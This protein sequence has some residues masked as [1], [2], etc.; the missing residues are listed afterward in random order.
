MEVLLALL[1]IFV[2]LIV[3]IWILVLLT[4][5]GRSVG[6]IAE[7]VAMLDMAVAGLRNRS[8]HPA[9][10]TPLQEDAQRTP[11]DERIAAAAARKQATS[12]D[13]SGARNTSPCPCG[14]SPFPEGGKTKGNG[15]T[16]PPSSK[17][18]TTPIMPP[19]ERG[20][21]AVPPRGVF[22][23]APDAGNEA[24]ARKDESVTTPP[25]PGSA[26]PS[27][28]P[29]INV[30][31]S[32]SIIRVSSQPTESAPLEPTL[33]EQWAKAVWNWLRVG[34]EWRPGWIPGPLAVAAV[35]L[36]RAA[37]LLLLFG[38][39]WF[40]R[41]VHE[42][43]WLPP[44]WRIV[45]GFAATAALIVAGA[46]LTRRNYRPIG[47]AL[48]GL[49][50]ALGEFVDWAGA[51]LYGVLSA[52]AAFGIAAVLTIGAGAMAWRH[53]SLL[54]ALV[55]LFAGYTAPLFFPE[56]VRGGDAALLGWLLL[57][58]AEAAALATARGWRCL[59]WIAIP[60]GFAFSVPALTSAPRLAVL[61][62]GVALAFLGV[63]AVLAWAQSLGHSLLRRREPIGL[64][65]LAWFLATVAS[66]VLATSVTT[67]W[68]VWTH[69][70]PCLALA[71]GCA[72]LSDS[73]TRRI[74]FDPLRTEVLRGVGGTLALVFLS[75]SFTGSARCV[76][77][78][79]AAVGCVAFASWRRSVAVAALALLAWTLWIGCVG[80]PSTAA[81][82]ALRIGSAVASLWASGLLLRRKDFG[83][84]WVAQGF[85]WAAWAASLVWGS[86]EVHHGL[87]AAAPALALFWSVYALATLVI[88]LRFARRDVRGA[89]LGLFALAAGKF[90]LVDQAGAA[91]PER[92]AGFLGVGLLLLLGSAVYI[93]SATRSSTTPE[94]EK[95]CGENPHA[96]SAESDS[97]AESAEP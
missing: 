41:Y 7:H 68:P 81:E 64:D 96:E 5:L 8:R 61:G 46:R 72:A 38:A 86:W 74:G 48:V 59:P 82:R 25:L 36:L 57:L 19:S 79:A 83:A 90:L 55:A 87:P 24:T 34:E 20:E 14:A 80:E 65:A 95:P 40:V 15:G 37:A 16:F 31:S 47:L 89:A 18:S 10:A 93:R 84:G 32:S 2:F 63:H 39:A 17:G 66:A 75:L 53:S 35:Q 50:F 52:P 12:A 42:Q 23:A 78:S 62:H 71:A 6:S 70:L 49:G 3:P 88:G 21:A 77:L 91:T 76:L 27:T 1:A 45:A 56:A 51:N 33:F 11:L 13:M 9:S 26:Q 97:H 29:M 69:G 4:D 92:V 67:P 44:G 73:F 28:P 58:A 30:P 94:A 54:L 22:R 43:G 85:L 60:A